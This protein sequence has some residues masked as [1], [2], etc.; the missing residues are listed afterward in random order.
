MIERKPDLMGNKNLALSN[1]YIIH[2]VVFVYRAKR[3]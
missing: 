1:Y 2:L 3:N